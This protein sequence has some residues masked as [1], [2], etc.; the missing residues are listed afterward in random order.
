VE[1][2][3]KDAGFVAVPDAAPREPRW[4]MVIMAKPR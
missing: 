4:F 3:L 2:E 1:R